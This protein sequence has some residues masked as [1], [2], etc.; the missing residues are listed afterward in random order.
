MPYDPI[1]NAEIESGDPITQNLMQKFKN[2]EDYLNGLIG[3]FN[4]LDIVNNSFEQDS[5]ADDTPDNWTWTAHPG[6]SKNIVSG[7]EGTNAFE[8]T[9]PSGASNGGG[10]LDSD[11]Y[12][13]PE[14]TNGGGVRYLSWLMKCSVATIGVKV[15]IRAY[16]GAKTWQSDYDIYSASSGNPT[17]WTRMLAILRGQSLPSDTRYIRI[18]LEGGTIGPG[19]AGTVE[20]DGV[21]MKPA[22]PVGWKS[23]NAWTGSP[24]TTTSSSFAQVGQT[25]FDMPANTLIGGEG[26]IKIE[27]YV[28]IQVADPNIGAFARVTDGGS[29]NSNEI[30]QYVLIPSDAGSTNVQLFHFT[31]IMDA[32]YAAT[33][34]LDI[35]AKNDDSTT[36]VT[37][38]DPGL[39]D[40]GSLIV[41]A[42]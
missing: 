32:S 31:L 24:H 15:T 3:Q 19:V 34:T 17:G 42:G 9:A 4:T 20:F 36:T 41:N 21:T 14:Y 33:Y 1:L 28:G 12:P 13:V 38:V 16:N 26:Q 30:R 2:N 23:A 40:T 35:E 29:N 8:F 10:T 5:D 39:D 18:R 37:L 6:G 27:G 7:M 11:Y 25:S 22:V